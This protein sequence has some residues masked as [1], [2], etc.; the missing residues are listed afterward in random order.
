MVDETSLATR[1]DAIAADLRL[2][3]RQRAFADVLVGDPMAT[4]VHALRTI[5]ASAGACSRKTPK[6]RRYIDEAIALNRELAKASGVA[7]MPTKNEVVMRMATRARA[8]MAD[9]MTFIP[10]ESVSAKV[11]NSTLL[12]PG[13]SPDSVAVPNAPEGYS[14][15]PDSR[16][17]ED[18]Q[19]DLQRAI[20]NGFGHCIKSIS[21][22]REGRPKIELVDGMAADAHLARWLG[23]DKSVAPPEDEDMRAAREAFR[24]MLA[25]NPDKARQLEDFSVELDRVRISIKGRTQ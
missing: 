17:V 3:K 14:R 4:D 21:F 12:T 23:I 10:R 22:D 5:G 25:S 19:L 20:K 18:F 13:N 1:L 6:I 9:F 15:D 2:T 8:N 7:L 11:E 16:L 24:S